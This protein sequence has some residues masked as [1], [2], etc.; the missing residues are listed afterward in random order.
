VRWRLPLV[1]MLALLAFGPALPVHARQAATGEDVMDLL[2]RLRVEEAE[3]LLRKVPAEDGARGLAEAAVLFHRGR[4]Q[5]ARDALASA[6][7]TPPELAERMAWLPERIGAAQAATAEMEERTIGNFVYR[8]TPGHDEVLVEYA[9][10]ALEGEREA[11]RQLLGVAPEQPTVVEFFPDVAG[12]VVASGLPKEWV[13]TTG[14]V[15]ISKWDRLLVLSPMNMA[16]GY[17]WMDTLAHEYVHLALARASSNH[18]PVWFQEGS[19]KVLESAWR[20]GDRRRFL[21]PYA[22]SLLAR[23]LEEDALIPFAS[24]H[25]SMA[26][27]PSSDA[28]ALAFGQVACAIDYLL[29]EGGDE[30]YRR[31]VDQTALHGD[32]T[33]AI[34][35]VLG[36]GGRF[37]GRYKRHMRTLGLEVRAN[38]FGFEPELASGAGAAE[39]EA[40]EKLDPVLLAHRR[41]RDLTRLGDMLR[42]R[43]HMEAALLEYEEAGR[44]GPYHSPA[45][46]GKQARA[47][48][49]LGR[50]DEARELLADSVQLYPEYTPTIT[51]LAELAALAGNDRVAAEMGV[52]SLWLN[53]FDPNVHLQLIEV[54]ERS[55]DP[56]RAERERRVLELLAT[57]TPGSR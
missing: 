13:E 17:P 15:A 46:A 48:R 37:E 50:T 35:L 44:T 16:R 26:A 24:M 31:V 22:E 53:P 20:D 54:Y 4:Y 41:M 40:G 43:G 47:L 34:D 32:V 36:R 7:G 10:E 33:R 51:M 8:F 23:A 19:A 38:V 57:N 39:D 27:L 25:P 14:T 6:S 2:V 30:G 42:Q 9:A 28:A 52:R 5:E 49:G 55:G 3:A 21:S 45:L 29:E 12:L 18:A 56:S 11:M 1:L